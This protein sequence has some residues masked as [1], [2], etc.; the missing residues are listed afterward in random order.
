MPDRSGRGITVT[1]SSG[2][3]GVHYNTGHQPGHNLTHLPQ[4]PA[5]SHNIQQQQQQYYSGAVV[6]QGQLAQPQVPPGQFGHNYS[7]PVAAVAPQLRHVPPRDER[8]D[9]NPGGRHKTDKMTPGGGMMG[10]MESLNSNQDSVFSF[11]STISSNGKKSKSKY[12][13]RKLTFS[14]YS[15]KYQQSPEIQFEEAT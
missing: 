1:S 14:F 15:S 8:V 5:P 9:L 4:F 6:Q 2:V 11:G 10:S 3:P 7:A 13:S 12:L